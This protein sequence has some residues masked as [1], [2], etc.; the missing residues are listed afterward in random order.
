MK[1]TTAWALATTLGFAFSGL[2]LAADS[3]DAAP[4]MIKEQE[5]SRSTIVAI[6]KAQRTVTLKGP[7]GKTMELIVDD[8][9]TRF[10]ALKVGDIVMAGYSESAKFEIQA[11]GTP[12]AP[13]SLVRG[14][15]KITGEKPG[16]AA[17]DTTVRTVT[18]TAIDA[19]APTVTVKNSDGGSEVYHVRHPEYL[20][21][22]KVGDQVRVT[23]TKAL[24]VKVDAAK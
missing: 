7:E 10:D 24:L 17:A 1:K 12:A 19:K 15:G 18:I 3:K 8:A 14:G 11:P 21:R 6:D 4:V 2:S 20:D 5:T 13:D 9:V 16:G 23:R 22:F